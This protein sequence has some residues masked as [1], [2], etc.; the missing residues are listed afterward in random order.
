VIKS[1]TNQ[2]HG[3]AFDFFRNTALDASDYFLQ[4]VPVLRRNIFGGTI[5]FPI[6]KNK[7]FL[8]ASYQGARR[9]EGQNPGPIT[10]LSAAERTGD[11]SELLPQGI[12]LY[13]PTSGNAYQNNQVPLDPII[14][15]Y[16]KAYLPLPNRPGNIFIAD[17]VANIRDNQYIFRFDYN[18]TQKDLISATYIVDNSPQ[19]YPFVVGSY[20]GD[21]P[22][23]S[24]ETDSYQQQAVNVAW[25]RT[26]TP[27]LVNEARISFNRSGSLNAV[28]TNTTTPA[29]LGFSNVN[30]DDPHG[31]A[32]PPM[33]VN[34]AFNLGPNPG[35]PTSIHDSTYQYQDTISWTHGRH[36][37]KF[38]GDFRWVEDNFNFDYY[39]NGSYLFQGDYTGSDL[40][41]FVGGFFYN[42]YQFSNAVYG[43]R[44]HSYYAFGQDSWKL[45]KNL[46]LSYGLRYEYNAPQ[47]DPHNEII[48]WYPGRQSTVYPDAPPNFLYP[49]DAG[50]P[51]KGLIFPDKNNFAPRFG[52]AWDTFGNSKFVVR[53]GGGIFY[54]IEDGA[55][56]LQFGGQ[57]PFGYVANIYPSWQG[58]P[59]GP[60]VSNVSDPFTNFGVDNPFPFAGKTGTFFDPK[61]PFAYVVTPHF[62]TP[63][64]EN[65]NFGFQYQ[66][67]KSTVVEAVY[68]GSLS[69]KSILSAETNYPTQ[70]NLTQQYL[71]GGYYGL[72][73]E[74]ARPLA[75]CDVNGVPTGAQEIL[76]NLS[77]GSSSS[78]EFQLTVDQR[79]S[80][81]VQFR[82]AYTNAKTIDDSS[83]F[84]ARSSTLTDPT[85]PA[86]DRG[87]ADFD[88][89]Q[90]L[91]LSPIWELPLDKPFHNSI[92]KKIAAGWS[93]ATIATF[94]SGNPFTLFS[95]NNSSQLD[96]YLDRP[97]VTGPIQKFSNLRQQ[98]TF[99]PNSNGIQG[100]CLTGTSTGIFLF[101]PTNLVCSV[102]NPIGLPPD[103]NLTPGGVPLFTH[104]NMGRNVLRGPGIN[105]WD[106][107][108]AKEIK[109]TES[110]S[111]EFRTEFYNA[112]NHVQ[113]NSPTLQAGAI[114]DG[115]Q[116]GQITSD[117]GSPGQTGDGARIIQFALKIYF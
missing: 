95:E 13:D 19:Q 83:G 75:A 102:G 17:P 79:L 34:G 88:A 46:T 92:A 11:F 6:I 49:G 77:E 99:S 3:S 85:N 105:N 70:A 1:G 72:N 113:F 90:R 56:N 55:L 32:P 112:F 69:R 30:P 23:G 111:I 94:Q 29:Q 115:G 58:I 93:V 101:N 89:P 80:H 40:A 47:T 64:A 86:V 74:C 50:T 104:G 7:M 4:E 63:Y 2:I 28:P 51:N 39:N 5:G 65:F 91:V 116:F 60:G 76:T 20:G 26:I 38:G 100:S 107:S 15:N 97:D 82:I 98:Q 21:V 33:E 36:D 22:V 53:G 48:G 27:T 18:V 41:D 108:I 14:A 68:V 66:A 37:M 106:F 57:P 67:T 52:F 16:I 110:K 61:I 10:V 43:I 59:Q 96:S 54:D 24:G 78:N 42:Y 31:A 25:T 84:R 71:A 8:F 109:L 73:P 117:R 44:T 45:T 87:L 62:R 103:P 12:Q 35:G 114:G 81:G 9:S